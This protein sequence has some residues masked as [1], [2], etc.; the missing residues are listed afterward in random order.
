MR[1]CK[2]GD[3]P[4]LY[5]VTKT[6][7]TIPKEALLAFLNGCVEMMLDEGNINEMINEAKRKNMGLHD[8]AVNFQRDVMEHN[9]QIERE[10]GCRYL[11]T[12]PD[13]HPGD[14]E[15]IDATKNFMFTALKSYLKALHQRS[16]RYKSGDLQAPSPSAPMTKVTIL[17]F[18]E[19]CNALSKHAPACSLS[20]ISFVQ[21]SQR[22][23]FLY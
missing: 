2:A 20:V 5:D 3:K 15:L 10:F 16:R 14:T 23:V 12:I 11:A 13:N 1:R 18:M 21:Y 4:I 22:C 9:F 17:E 8:V 19:G 6:S 7:T